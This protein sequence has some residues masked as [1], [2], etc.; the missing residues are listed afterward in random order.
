MPVELLKEVISPELIDCQEMYYW[1][2]DCSSRINELYNTSPF[3]L[4]KQMCT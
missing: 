4:V 2:I 3:T 1:G